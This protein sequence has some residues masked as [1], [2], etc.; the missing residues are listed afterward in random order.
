MQRR[1]LFWSV[2]RMLVLGAAVVAL[3]QV[4]AKPV[5]ACVICNGPDTCQSWYQGGSSCRWPAPG[6]FCKQY[7]AC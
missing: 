2:T 5:K 1:T 6:Y 4:T 3:G 7:G